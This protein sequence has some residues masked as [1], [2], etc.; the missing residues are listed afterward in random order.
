M[1][2]DDRTEGFDDHDHKAIGCQDARLDQEM[3]VER[4]SCWN[5]N[6]CDAGG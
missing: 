6:G 1:E 2:D 4:Q 5:V 3:R